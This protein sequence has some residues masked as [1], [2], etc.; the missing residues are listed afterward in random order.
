MEEKPT[1]SLRALATAA[2]MYDTFPGTIIPFQVCSCALGEASW[3]P[4]IYHWDG[5]Y[6]T[7]FRLTRAEISACLALFESG[8]CDIQPDALSRVMAMSTGDFLYIAECLLSDPTV[9]HSYI[10][11]WCVIW[12]SLR[13][14]SWVWVRILKKIIPT[15]SCRVKVRNLRAKRKAKS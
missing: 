11:I 5:T 1:R 6:R 14:A 8:A 3:I 9:E 2:S 7:I 10:G 13:G 12:R 15:S 4:K